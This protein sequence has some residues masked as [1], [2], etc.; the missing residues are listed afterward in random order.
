MRIFSLVVTFSNYHRRPS[1]NRGF[2]FHPFGF[3]GGLYDSQTGLVRF[4]ARDYDAESGRWASKDPI[5]FDGGDA[6]LYRY[7]GNDAVNFI[8]PTG[9]IGIFAAVWLGAKIYAWVVTFD[10]VATTA[11][12]FGKYVKE[13]A[14]KYGE[15]TQERFDAVVEF[16]GTDKACERMDNAQKAH[17]KAYKNVAKSTS[18]LGQLTHQLFGVSFFPHEHLISKLAGSLVEVGT[19]LHSD[20]KKGENEL[21]ANK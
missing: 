4:G 12:E 15:T 5:R 10:F 18:A 14:P 8:D 3:T 1:N 19:S 6:N 21:V 13:T 16:D 17:M 20:G 11:L 2:S 7:C 9:E